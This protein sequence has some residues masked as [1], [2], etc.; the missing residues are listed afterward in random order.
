[1]LENVT[2]VQ[3]RSFL[4]LARRRNFTHAAADLDYT[5]PAVHQQIRA[6]ERALG[7]N[8][9]RRRVTPVAL[10]EEGEALLP[11]IEALLDQVGEISAV[12]RNLR[13]QHRVVLGAAENTG[14]SLLLPML[15]QRAED[16][17]GELDLQVHD[18]EHLV[19]MVREGEVDVAMSARFGRLLGERRAD[20]RLV[21]WTRDQLVLVGGPGEC[22]R[23]QNIFIPPYVNAA[24]VAPALVS[25]HPAGR[26]AP[27]LTGD[28]GR[29]AALADMGLAVLPVSAVAG[30]VREG[31]LRVVGELG[32]PYR[33]SLLHRHA[34]ALNAPTRA[35]IYFLLKHRPRFRPTCEQVQASV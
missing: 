1:M 27:V 5:P 33:V 32:R 11:H 18:A 26:L 6:L 29:A 15:K 19:E 30:D 10:T 34:P 8:L 24:N 16:V 9:V 22:P 35:L 20:L 3:L 21:P 12:A 17:P 4:A 23:T 28:A 13:T 7:M 14:T 2:L 25:S 31:R